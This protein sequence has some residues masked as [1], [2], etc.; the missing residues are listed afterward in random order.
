M[1]IHMDVYVFS[2]IVCLV[3]GRGKSL[4]CWWHRHRGTTPFCQRGIDADSGCGNP[5]GFWIQSPP[6]CP[7]DFAVIASLFLLCIGVAIW[8]GAVG[9]VST[10]KPALECTFVAIVTSITTLYA[11][12]ES[13]RRRDVEVAAVIVVISSGLSW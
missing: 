7:C 11:E 5:F 12:T 4:V 13:W 9:G 1:R 10:G 6:F 8:V 3:Q 2:M